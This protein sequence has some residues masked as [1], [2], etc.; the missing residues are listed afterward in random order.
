M[1]KY[2]LLLLSLVI[3]TQSNAQKNKKSK[4]W[5]VKDIGVSYKLPVSWR[6]DPFS[7]SSVCHCP[8]TI[9]DNSELDEEYLGMVVYTAEFPIIDTANRSKVW[10]YH[11]ESSEDGEKITVN[12]IEFVKKKGLMKEGDEE[13]EAW[14]YVSVDT[15]ESNGVYIIIYFWGQHKKFA[16]NEDVLLEIIS[17]VNRG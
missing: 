8:G 6:S 3:L 10:G 7:S 5:T 12:G 14:Q 2:I 9:N 1:K 15:P 11:F 16:H 13:N 17:S 4:T